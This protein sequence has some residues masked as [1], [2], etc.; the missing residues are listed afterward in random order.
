MIIFSCEC[1]FNRIW[2]LSYVHN[3]LL[4]VLYCYR[5]CSIVN[6]YTCESMFAYRY[7]F[8]LFRNLFGRNKYEYNEVS[9]MYESLLVTRCTQ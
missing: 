2:Q 3:Y 7:Y 5:L 6:V 1:P 9:F 4:I 8:C